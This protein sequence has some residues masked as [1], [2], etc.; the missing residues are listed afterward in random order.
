[1]KF[2][3]KDKVKVITVR[4]TAFDPVASVGGSASGAEKVDGTFSNTA[5]T[6]VGE[7]LSKSDRPELASA[8]TVVS[9]GRLP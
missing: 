4:P 9:G 8:T 1:M 6:F 7:E 3:S 5:S 2:K